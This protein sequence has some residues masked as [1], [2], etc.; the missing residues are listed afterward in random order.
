[1]LRK[2]LVQCTVLAL[3]IL[4]G[5]LLYGWWN[6][7]YFP[8]PRLTPNIAVNEKVDRIVRLQREGADVLSSYWWP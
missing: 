1:M 3:P 5:I 2:F 6:K 7:T 8:A 4:G